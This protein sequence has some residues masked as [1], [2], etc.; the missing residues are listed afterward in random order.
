MQ[1]KNGK[2]SGYHVDIYFQTFLSLSNVEAWHL[3]P[4]SSCCDFT[5][6]LSLCNCLEVTP[7]TCHPIIFRHYTAPS[8][9]VVC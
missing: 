1:S 7:L 5:D 3:V 2:V 4:S 9:A 6:A 8:R